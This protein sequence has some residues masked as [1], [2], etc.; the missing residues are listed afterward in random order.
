[1]NPFAHRLRYAAATLVCFLA[2]GCAK[3]TLDDPAQE[4]VHTRFGNFTLAVSSEE[5]MKQPHLRYKDREIMLD[6]PPVRALESA[7]PTPD[8][9]LPGCES[10]KTEVFTGGANCCFGY[11]LLTQCPDGA[12]A[13][14]L[15]PFDGGLGEPEVAL[16]AYPVAD[17][18]FMYYSPENQ[19][20]EDRLS[21]N[22]PESPRVTR[23]IV[24]D[25][26]MWRAARVGEFQEAYTRL[27]AEAVRD[28]NLAPEARAIAAAYYSLMAGSPR[29]VTAKRFTTALP[30]KYRRLADT[31]F[32]DIEKAVAGFAPV[33][34]LTIRD[35]E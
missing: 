18:A 11:Y 19:T 14:Y 31:M 34:N 29:A 30:E 27:A 17:P 2:C 3:H 25:A 20:G 8:F 15:E 33:T 7:R 9:P 28:A 5:P 35:R 21:F 16:R 10:Q 4:G 13:A 22:R 12:Y 26:G 1:M 6:Q 23:H 24:F 32:A